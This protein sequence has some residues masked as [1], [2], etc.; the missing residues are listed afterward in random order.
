MMVLFWS[1]LI[2]PLVPVEENTPPAL[3]VIVN[4]IDVAVRIA[5][6]AP[7]VVI[8]PELVMVPPPVEILIAVRPAEIN[9]PALLVRVKLESLL[10]RI[11]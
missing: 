4:P 8:V 11:V 10:T 6:P 9:P 7:V 2:T 3:L 5:S 1:N